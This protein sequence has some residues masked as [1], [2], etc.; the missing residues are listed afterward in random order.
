MK[1]L[2]LL[3]V[4]LLLCVP[5]FA[6]TNEYV[7]SAMHQIDVGE[8]LCTLYA[9]GPHT[10]MTAEHC[11]ASVVSEITLDPKSTHPQKVEV[12]KIIL[13]KHDHAI[14]ELKGVKF[15]DYVDV[16]SR[17]V[18]QQGDKVH[19][20]GASAALYCSDCYVEGYYSGLA[21][22]PEDVAE[23]PDQVVMWFV[24][25]TTPGDSG[26]LIFN[27]NNE[28]V[29]MISIGD[30]TNTGSFIFAFT[31]AEWQSAKH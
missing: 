18:P 2:A 4:A 9:T 15:S 5:S 29:G 17:A 1:R 16:D 30:G 13:D 10:G 20:W 8:G 19:L 11:T 28:I 3:F 31:E 21:V 23:L 12:E 6:R 22:I 24:L 26:S 7:H 27:Q 25:P 14:V